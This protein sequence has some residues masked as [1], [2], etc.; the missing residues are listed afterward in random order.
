MLILEAVVSEMNH[1]VFLIFD[2]LLTIGLNSQSQVSRMEKG[3]AG[4][5]VE[6]QI[7]ANIEL[8]AFD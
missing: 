7:A 1:K 8:L 2:V 6:E 5:A 3:Y 4:A